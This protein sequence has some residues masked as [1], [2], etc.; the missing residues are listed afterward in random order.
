MFDVGGPHQRDAVF[1]A[2]ISLGTLVVFFLA[3]AAT[4]DI[5]HGDND[6]LEWS[7]LVASVPLFAF[8]Y[9]TAL[10]VLPS[11][12][13]MIW[14]G[15]TGLLFALFDFAAIH[16]TLRPKYPADPMLASLFLAAGVPV[17]ALIAYHLVRE[18]GRPRQASE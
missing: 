5:A 8:L 1:L 11:R 12:A 16:T 14:L 3:G 18:T 17:L 6:S 9:A 4:H 15:C 7:V 13:K 10:R 2:P